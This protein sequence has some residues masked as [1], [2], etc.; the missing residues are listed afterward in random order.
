MTREK[1]VVKPASQGDSNKWRRAKTT[2]QQPIAEKNGEVE[3]DSGGSLWFTD[4]QFLHPRTQGA[5]I[6]VQDHRRTLLAL[7]NPARAF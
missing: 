1:D 5:G 6:E 2:G 3:I 7:D 4:V